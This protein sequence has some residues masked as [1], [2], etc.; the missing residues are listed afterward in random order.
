MS[1][2]VAGTRSPGVTIRDIECVNKTYPE[3]FVDLKKL[4]DNS[5]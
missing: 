1:F 2:A 4:R 5:P 3:F